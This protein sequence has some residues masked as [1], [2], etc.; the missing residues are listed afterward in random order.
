MA[1]NSA[2]LRKTNHQRIHR[3]QLLT[4]SDSSFSNLIRL[5]FIHNPS[6]ELIKHAI[7]QTFH[8]YFINDS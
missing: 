4:I 1:F 6:Y 7:T 2:F 8:Y 5:K 3:N